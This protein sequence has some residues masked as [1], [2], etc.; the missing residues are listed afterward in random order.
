VLLVFPEPRK[1]VMMVMG[2][3]VRTMSGIDSRSCV[4]QASS[5]PQFVVVAVTIDK[6]RPN[7]LAPAVVV[8]ARSRALQIPDS[9][10]HHPC[11]SIAGQPK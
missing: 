7:I 11:A 1:P 8:L 9:L 4:C 3:I 2:I 10:P 6:R 5:T